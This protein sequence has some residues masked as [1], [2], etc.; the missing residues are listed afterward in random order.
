MGTEYRITFEPDARYVFP[1]APTPNDLWLRHRARVEDHLRDMAECTTRGTAIELRVATNTGAMP[2]VVVALGDDDIYVCEYGDRA[3]AS[4][5]VG[6]IV[7]S[8]ADGGFVTT[9]ATLE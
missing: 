5:V 8:L 3:L 4:R 6:A 1:A 7:M 9:L 2:D